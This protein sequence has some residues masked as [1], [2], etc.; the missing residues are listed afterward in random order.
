[1]S[2]LSELWIVIP[3]WER[4]QHYDPKM[5]T[6]PWIKTYLRL[7]SDDNYLALTEH[8]AL[9]LHRLWLEYASS[10]CQLRADTASL[11]R[12]LFVRVTSKD[13]EALNHAGYI[14]FSLAPGGEPVLAP[15]ARSREVEVEKNEDLTNVRKNPRED[16][17]EKTREEHDGEDLSKIAYEDLLRTITGVIDEP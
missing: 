12:H 7:M 14:E 17:R 2:Y 9:I 8:R 4:F 1:V 10:S 13:L 15:R 16:A 3:K 6:P 11:S 5:R